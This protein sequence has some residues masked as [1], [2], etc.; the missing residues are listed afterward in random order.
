MDNYPI[1]FTIIDAWWLCLLCSVVIIVVIFLKLF[2]M[3]DLIILVNNEKKGTVE[4]FIKLNVI[5]NV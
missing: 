3:A 2:S 4:K 1:I 5:Y